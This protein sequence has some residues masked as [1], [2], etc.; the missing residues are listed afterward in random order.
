MKNPV[1]ITTDGLSENLSSLY[2]KDN[3]NAIQIE[4]AVEE[5]QTGAELAANLN[6]LKLF[7]KFRLDRETTEYARLVT[8]DCWGNVHYFKAWK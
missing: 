4:D 5:S 8:T 3:C 2:M 7:S 1:L 6:R